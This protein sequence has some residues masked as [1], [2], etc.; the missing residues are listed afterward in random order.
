M[1]TA[2][3]G[4]LGSFALILLL[5][6]LKVPLGL[7]ILVGAGM[8]G[9]VFGTPPMDILLSALTSVIDPSTIAL[10]VIVAFLLALSGTMEAGGQMQEIVSLAKKFFRRPA[11]TMAAL[12]AMIGLLPM[13]GGALFSAPMVE[14]VAGEG[15]VRGAM[16]SGINYWFRHVW[17]YWWPLFPGVIL[18]TSLVESTP[19]QFAA[20]QLPMGIVMIS[21][22][23]LLL[24][25]LHPS[26]HA[27]APKAP[28]GTKRKLLKATAPIWII[29]VVWLPATLAMR[30]L[31]ESFA[32]TEV[33]KAIERFGPITLGVAVSVVWTTIRRRLDAGTIRRIWTSKSACAM[34]GLVISVMVFQ[35]I[36]KTADAAGKI[37]V[38]L[39]DMGVPVV[40]VAALLPFIAGAVTGLA[41]GFVGT[42]FPIILGLVAAVP[43]QN[44]WPYVVLAYGFGHM[45]QMLSPMHVC[46]IVSNRY[47]KTSFGPV[48]RQIVPSVIVV[49]TFTVA[50]FLLLRAILN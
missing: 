37:G 10:L 11:V 3:L 46:Q 30:M 6:R 43:G 12:P 41:V 22:G 36:L 16:L 18:A 5:A 24:R 23:L 2:L 26:L 38:E 50:Y 32:A 21:S 13:P 17:E 9:A 7:S 28:G 15:Q 45:G 20:V 35:H 49:M 39:T 4:M 25:R 31:G 29:L 8:V 27:A 44:V 48:Y 33:G 47:F 19:A 14:S 40:V 1:P 34:I 42:S